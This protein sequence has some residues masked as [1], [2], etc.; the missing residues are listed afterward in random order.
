MS[1]ISLAIRIILTL[2]FMTLLALGSLAPGRPEPAALQKLLHVGFYAVLV[3]L[4]AWTLDSIES[5]YY[6]LLVS[7]TIAVAFG[8]AMEWYQ[9]RV[10]GRFGSLLDVALN[11]AGAAVGVLAA[12]FLL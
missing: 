5:G 7:W 3:L 10:P 12:A 2:C 4:L 11:A 9:T 1:S 6:R 8:A